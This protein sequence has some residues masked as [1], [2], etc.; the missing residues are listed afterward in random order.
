MIIDYSISWNQLKE[1]MDKEIENHD[2]PVAY[3]VL[4]TKMNKEFEKFCD[5]ID[6]SN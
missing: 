6:K 1:R 2:E 5:E 4:E 3:A